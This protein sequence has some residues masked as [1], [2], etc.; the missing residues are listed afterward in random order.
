MRPACRLL[1]LVI[2]ECRREGSPTY[3]TKKATAGWAAVLSWGNWADR[4]EAGEENFSRDRSCP[5]WNI[6]HGGTSCCRLWWWLRSDWDNT[7]AYRCTP[8]ECDC[9]S[10]SP[11]MSPDTTGCLGKGEHRHPCCMAVPLWNQLM[12]CN[13]WRVVLVMGS[14]KEWGGVFSSSCC[15]LW[16]PRGWW[17]WLWL[18]MKAH[19][20]TAAACKL[21]VKREP[22][23]LTSCRSDQSPVG[24]G[25]EDKRFRI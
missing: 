18:E 20:C 8:T 16:G 13:S 6:P 4:E 24:A 10:M 11:G 21:M 7:G 12:V 5:Q 17:R 22:W 23:S 15:L 25:R 3:R 2:P 1:D 19:R 9:T 14:V